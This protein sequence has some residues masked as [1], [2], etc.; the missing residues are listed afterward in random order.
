MG[1]REGELNRCSVSLWNRHRELFLRN[2]LVALRGAWPASELWNVK[3]SEG[4]LGVGAGVGGGSGT[5]TG[6]G[7][8]SSSLWME[9]EEAGL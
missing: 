7:E 3:G 1:L 5:G 6:D 2:L 4:R 9:G 8:D